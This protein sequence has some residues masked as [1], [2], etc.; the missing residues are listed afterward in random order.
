MGKGRAFPVEEQQNRGQ[1]EWVGL[2]PAQTGWN[3]DAWREVKS[4]SWFGAEAGPSLLLLFLASPLTACL[5]GSVTGIASFLTFWR[6]PSH[7]DCAMVREGPGQ[8][9][10]ASALTLWPPT[11]RG[12]GPPEEARQLADVHPAAPGGWRWAAPGAVPAAGGRPCAGR[13][14]PHGGTL[15]GGG[16]GGISDGKAAGGILGYS[17]GGNRSLQKATEAF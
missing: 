13:K 9:P 14:D 16:F 17:R 12:S 5:P 3:P 4:E 2:D 8:T 15:P 6:P 11:G 7:Q 10:Q 1:G